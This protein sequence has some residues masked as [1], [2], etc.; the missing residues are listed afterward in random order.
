MVHYLTR[1]FE[2]KYIAK[3]T[4]SHPF[5]LIAEITLTGRRFVNNTVHS[6]YFLRTIQGPQN[7][8]ELRRVRIIEGRFVESLLS[9][10]RKIYSK[11]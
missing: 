11:N 4:L 7:L 1:V 3:E 9:K 6:L 2:G 10:E 8:F 5:N